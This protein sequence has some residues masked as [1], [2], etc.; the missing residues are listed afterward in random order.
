[1]ALRL[2]V[3]H[4][5]GLA[6]NGDGVRLMCHLGLGPG[7]IG[8]ANETFDHTVL[9]YGI[10]ADPQ[11]ASLQG[12][13]PY[14]S[15][16]RLLMQFAR[17]VSSLLH[18]QAALDL[19]VLL[20][21]YCLVVGGVTAALCRLVSAGWWGHL[22]VATAVVLVAGD[23]AVATFP[24]S[25]FTETAA[26]FGLLV[27]APAGVALARSVEGRGRV[28]RWGALVCFAAAA[29]L[30]V[31]A[32]VQM[33]TA[34]VPLLA[35]VAWRTARGGGRRR[36][37]T[38][39]ATG[40]VVGLAVGAIALPALVTYRDNP[41]EFGVINATDTLFVGIL[42]T[43]A[44]PAADLTELGLPPE[45]ARFAGASWWDHVPPQ[46]DP[47]FVQVRGRI[48]YRTIAGFLVAHPWR[49]AEVADAGAKAF[50][51][52]RPSD[53]G[54]Y[55]RGDGPA[56]ATECRLCVLSTMMSNLQGMGL[57]AY[58]AIASAVV[59]GALIVMRRGAA[60]GRG[61]SLAVTSLLFSAVSALQF[62]TCAYG[63]AIET[64]KHMSLAVLSALLAGLLLVLSVMAR[65][66]P[67]S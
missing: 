49:A 11:A 64:T 31:S 47:A 4:P 39:L 41:K 61:H 1:M 19:R 53:L 55:Q 10:P 58:V 63:E 54:N 51:A 40:L 8:T 17:M 7:R 52:A 14:P 9:D 2:F 21:L 16:T 43:S 56:R 22:V 50:L 66:R 18:L 12:C 30:T 3:P 6:D 45:M 60:G 67:R 44:H 25:P 15:S 34:A 65:E 42:G 36:W 32:K 62:L 27:L 46:S 24:G 57:V 20:V 13:V 26:V 33:V 48:S 29:A 5:V 37:H 23:S 35:F 28:M 59:A 38:Q